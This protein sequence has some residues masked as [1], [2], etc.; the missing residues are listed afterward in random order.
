MLPWA[1]G[2][3]SKEKFDDIFSRN[4][5][6]KMSD[7]NFQ[8]ILSTEEIIYNKVTFS[9]LRMGLNLG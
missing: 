7:Q 2:S 1:E 3:S 5:R 8:S 6:H 4:V 9:L